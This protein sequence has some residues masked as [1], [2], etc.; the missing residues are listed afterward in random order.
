M[1][2]SEC[3]CADAAV[4]NRNLFPL[5]YYTVYVQPL[6]K[7]IK[8]N[9]SQAQHPETQQEWARVQKIRGDI[10]H[11]CKLKLVLWSIVELNLTS[12]LSCLVTVHLTCSE[13]LSCLARFLL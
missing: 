8:C 11:Q 2:K 5:V 13:G 12:I 7:L 9:P 10:F 1:S 6:H 4:A 3:L